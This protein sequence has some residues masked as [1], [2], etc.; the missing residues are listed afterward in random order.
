[1]EASEER[2]R[3]GSND[4]GEKKCDSMEK[5][6]GKGKEKE[7]GKRTEKGKETCVGNI[8]KVVDSFLSENR[9]NHHKNL[10]K[11]FERRII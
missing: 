2:R 11:K 9:L 10:E 1:M 5:E 7:K 3:G 8:A 6:T 4:Q